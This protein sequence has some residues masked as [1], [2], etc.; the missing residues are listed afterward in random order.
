MTGIVIGILL[1][2]WGYLNGQMEETES[3]SSVICTSCL[4]IEE[5]AP[6]LSLIDKAE[7]KKVEDSFNPTLFTA[8]RCEGCPK[9]REFLE[10]IE[11]IMGSN[12]TYQEFDINENEKLAEEYE[13][14][15]VPTVI[16]DKVK[17]EGL[18]EIR[19]KLVPLILENT[20]E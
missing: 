16:I 14:G 6:K 1:I 10:S 15:F 17:L 9:A 12:M 3:Y 18:S 13:I 20:R 4:G 8:E 11:S 19:N 5:K 7:L 2:G